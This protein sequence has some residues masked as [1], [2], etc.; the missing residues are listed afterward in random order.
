MLFVSLNEVGNLESFGFRK[1]SDLQLEHPYRVSE[2]EKIMTRFGE[3]VHQEL[4][5]FGWVLLPER[6]NRVVTKKILR[7]LNKVESTLFYKGTLDVRKLQPA[8][9]LEFTQG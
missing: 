9:L 6:F 1:L 5:Y 8:Y 2:A 7:E 4:E 3:K